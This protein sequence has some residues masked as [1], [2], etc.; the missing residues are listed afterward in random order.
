MSSAATIIDMAKSS[1]QPKSI[2]VQGRLSPE[3]V[4]ELDEA[5]Q[6]QSVPVDRSTLVSFILRKWMGE[7]RAAKRHG[8]GK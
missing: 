5:A 2:P 4:K 6:E 1:L 3:E 8:K 7:R